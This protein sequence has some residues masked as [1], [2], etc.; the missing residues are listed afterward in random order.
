MKN[1]RFTTLSPII[2]LIGFLKKNIATQAKGKRFG[3]LIA[4]GLFISSLALGWAA[5]PPAAQQLP[6]GLFL[7]YGPADFVRGTGKPAPDTRNF[8]L[9][10]T[11]TEYRLQIFNGGLDAQF[12]GAA[13]AVVM[14][15]GQQVASPSDFN[16]SVRL[17][18]RSF[19]PAFANSLAVELRSSPKSGL[20]LQVVGVD[21]NPPTINAAAAPAANTNG[22]NNTN[23]A[24]SFTCGDS[25]SGIETCSSPALISAEGAG[26]VVTGTATDRAQ[27]SS[28]ASVSLNL[29][30]TAPSIN[31]VATPSANAN[32]WNNTDVTVNFNCGDSLSGIENCSSPMI[33]TTDGAS[34]MVTGTAIDRAHNS[35]AAS[36]TVNLDKTAPAITINSPA[37]GATVT[38]A[39][40][41]VTGTLT[42][43]TSGVDIVTCGGSPATLSGANF[44][45]V[46]SLTTGLNA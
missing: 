23:V 35:R 6:R 12:G 46:Q 13:S 26:Q 31:A 4:L 30:K 39:T 17:L 37:S 16:L 25:I 1:Q 42:D 44:T 40:V 9:A 36:L 45:C 34:Q 20:S 21:N 24:V 8:S 33:L 29:D 7:A 38:D 19:T 11:Q 14:L 3:L 27:N 41:T 43:S 22:W 28:H 10:N 2:G 32:G 15:N 18:E 5:L